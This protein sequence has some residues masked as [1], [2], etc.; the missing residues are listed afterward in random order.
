[1]EGLSFL[2]EMEEM[3]ETAKTEHKD[4]KEFLEGS[5]KRRGSY[6]GYGSKDDYGAGRATDVSRRESHAPDPAP[7]PAPNSFPYTLGTPAPTPTHFLSLSHSVTL[8]NPNPYRTQRS[9]R[10][11]SHRAMARPSRRDP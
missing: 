2:K 6:F 5:S 7:A 9:T 3:K 4:R 1:M 11:S 10:V 8:P